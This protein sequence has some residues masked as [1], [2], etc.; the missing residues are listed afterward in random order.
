MARKGNGERDAAG[1]RQDGLLAAVRSLAWRR[2]AGR[3]ADSA[4]HVRVHGAVIVGTVRRHG[5]TSDR[6]PGSV[7]DV[8]APAR[9]SLQHQA[10]RAAPAQLAGLAQKGA[11]EIGRDADL[12]VLDADVVKMIN[13]SELQHRHKITPYDGM[14]LRGEVD[15]TFLRGQKIYEHGEFSAP[16]GQLLQRTNRA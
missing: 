9:P 14:I 3:S 11:I 13:A 2:P 15:V 5:P 6:V 12:V 4:N 7:E 1:C 16:C 10:T 8:P